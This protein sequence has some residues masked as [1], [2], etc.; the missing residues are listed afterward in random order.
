[1]TSKPKVVAIIQARMLSQRLR[2][3]SLMPICGIP[4]IQWV[5]EK[6]RSLDFVDQ[7]IVATSD[8]PA[9]TPLATFA[10]QLG[11]EVF[12]GHK[13]DVLGRFVGAAKNLRDDDIVIRYTADNPMYDGPKTQALLEA[14]INS[15]SDYGCVDGLSHLV[16]EFIR[17]GCL[18]KLSELTQNHSDREHVTLFLRNQ[19]SPFGRFIGPRDFAGLRPQYDKDFTIDFGHQLESFEELIRSAKAANPLEVTLDECYS[20]LDKKYGLNTQVQPGQKRLNFA[21]V[22]IGDGC[23]CYIIAEIGQNHNGQ[24]NLAK[25]LIDMAARCGANAVKFQKREISWELTEEAY[26]KPYEGPNSFGRTYGAHREYLEL[27][28]KEHRELREYALANGLMYFC[29]PCDPP[30]VE[31]LERI[32]NPVYK[33]ASRDITN[34]PLLKVIA[35]TGKP[36]ILST[37]MAGLEEIQEAIDIFKS[38]NCPVALMQCVSQY[39]AD[40][41]NINLRA[42]QTLRE[43]FDVLVA[44]SDHTTGVITGVAGAVLGAFAIEKHI[45]L[46]RAMPGTDHGAALEEEGLR[47]MVSYIRISEEAMGDG[48]KSFNPVAQ[49]AKEKLARS[50]VSATAIP[51]GTKL[52][53]TML[54]L[55]SPGT[56]LPW[57][58]R[59]KIV[60]KIAK[61]DIAPHVTLS[62]NDF[63]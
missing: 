52:D 30:S 41:K 13:E 3:K 17:V 23:P 46:S 8:H 42:M 62:V 36:T 10:Y 9:D 33:V 7:V 24:L 59:D 43:K 25:K 14:F 11:V 58:E 56:G 47:R 27:G 21:G 31:M 45:T 15:Q 4:L 57:R 63:E 19:P 28:E 48:I 38:V 61:K 35:A 29:T 49:S 53:E 40:P 54:T 50:L 1:M 34:I 26:N 6:V 37:G 2:G 60:G 5:V 44:L 12:R 55:R 39:P 18:R 32:G 51:A 22:P 20:I 16:P